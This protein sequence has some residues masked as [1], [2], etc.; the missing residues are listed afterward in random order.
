MENKKQLFIKING[1]HRVNSIIVVKKTRKKNIYLNLFKG[2]ENDMNQKETMK[3]IF[4]NMV[5]GF[6]VRS[7]NQEEWKEEIWHFVNRFARLTQD[8][9][10]KKKRKRK[11]KKKKNNHLKSEQSHQKDLK[12]VF[13]FVIKIIINSKNKTGWILIPIFELKIFALNVIFEIIDIFKVIESI[14]LESSDHQLW[15]QWEKKGDKLRKEKINQIHG[16][17]ERMAW[18]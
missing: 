6:K 11:T 1:T 2:R 16:I 12:F 13:F 5:Y 7:S 8:A 4:K 10:I 15:E 9:D 3:S 14:G 17:G 18:N